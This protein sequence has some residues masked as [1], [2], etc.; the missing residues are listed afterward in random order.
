L[1]AKATNEILQDPSAPAGLNDILERFVAQDNGAT[2]WDKRTFKAM[3]KDGIEASG[4]AFN[5]SVVIDN[6]KY[7]VNIW[8]AKYEMQRRGEYKIKNKLKKVRETLNRLLPFLM[9]LSANF[10]TLNPRELRKIALQKLS[11]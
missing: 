2:V 8:D 1:V 6:E 9:Y 3:F 5:V 4:D 7:S 11:Q 10:E